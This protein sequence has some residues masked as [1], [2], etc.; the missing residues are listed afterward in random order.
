M[1]N[2]LS[3]ILII[4]L[5]IVMVFA[6]GMSASAEL[7]T[8]WVAGDH[9]YFDSA[10]IWAFRDDTDGVKLYDDLN[11]TFGTDND[12]TIEY[13]EDG[14]NKLILTCSN[15]FTLTGA[16]GITGNILMATTSQLQFHDS[17]INIYAASDSNMVINADG[18]LIITSPATKIIATTSLIHEY[19]S[20]SYVTQTVSNAGL[21]T[22]TVT[23][24][25]A[26]S[27]EIVAD[28]T[29]I[30][31]D[32]NTAV[33]LEAGAGTYG[34]SATTLD[35]N[36][37]TIT[38]CGKITANDAAGPAFIDEAVT[39]TNPTLCPNK[40]D[41]TLGVGWASNVLHL[42]VGGASELSV[43]ATAV[44][45]PTNELI[46][47][48]GNFTV[49]GSITQK[50]DA[51]DYVTTTVVATGTVKVTTTGNA[52][53]SYEI[54][55][56]DAAILL[57]AAT[58]VN[59]DAAGSMFDFT[60]TGL[61]MN[62]LTITE[63][64]DIDAADAAGPS[65]LNEAATATNP[66]L[67]PNQAEDD[68]GIGWQSDVIHIVLGTADEYSFSTSAVDFNSNN[69]GEVGTYSGT[70]A[71]TIAPTAAGT[72]LDFVLETEWVSGTL[73]NA[74][75][76]AGGVTIG[77][78]IIGMVL[79]FNANFTAVADHD[80]TG[81]KLLL[82]ALDSSTNVTTTYIGFDLNTAGAIDQSNTGTFVWK[83]INVQMPTTD[84]ATGTCTATGLHI[85]PGTITG[86]TQKGI[87][88]SGT[89]TIALDIDDATDASNLTTASVVIDGGV[90]IVKQLY[91]GDDL[92][93]S[94]SGTGVYEITLLNTNA[95]AL[96]IT[97][98]TGD[99]MVFKGTATRSVTVTPALIVTGKINT[100]DTTDASAIGTAALVS[101]GG[102]SCADELWMG[103]DIDMTTNGSGVYD[104]TLKDAVADALS[105]TRAGTDIIVFDT[106]T[107][108]VTITPVTTITGA[109]TLSG[110]L[111]VIDDQT[112]AFG[113]GSDVTMD[114]DN[115][116]GA[117]V[118]TPAGHWVAP[119]GISDRF[120]LT[121]V[122]GQRGT[123]EQNADIQD[124]AEATRMTVDPDFE[125]L[126][127]GGGA[128]STDYYA[129]GGIQL[130]TDG[131]EGHGLVMLPHLDADQT[132]WNYVTWGTDMETRW[133][134]S[135]KT[136]SV[137]T[138]CIIWAGLKLTN[139][140]TTATDNDQAFFAFDE[141]VNGGEWEAISSI[142]DS[143]DAHDTNVAVATNT[144]YHLVIEI[145]SSRLAKFYING[146]L[147]ETSAALTDTT[148]LIPYIGIEEDG[149]GGAARTL[150]IRGQAI[151]RK[152]E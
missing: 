93:M 16:L 98:G 152:F 76:A 109:L 141:D 24:D 135:I 95:D 123:P 67:I 51:D 29:T 57:D 55:T 79:D 111:I 32:A 12:A 74:D 11:L 4:P 85:T 18:T 45:L 70:G 146:T 86:G 47:T 110:G 121:W 50:F 96:S 46:I 17:A 69:L 73:I 84:E 129:E 115:T 99:F 113:T 15:G 44:T 38:E 108:K 34:F 5:L 31:L 97:D 42:V 80:I 122:A 89:Y 65:F 151:S 43:S 23:G 133:E 56:D 92:D 104:L 132:A 8:K 83:G 20:A 1:L 90:A 120:R 117:L 52:A 125:V 94:V 103:D 101:D 33:S 130:V 60:S 138:D 7:H 82:P 54:E 48:A 22:V 147:V 10:N 61:E 148:D 91:L 118:T 2:K 13:D 131:T 78:D 116:R 30:V 114:W 21:V 37:L 27:Y 112:V 119:E 126:G 106:S 100:D 139:V 39:S 77:A 72:F 144:V 107:P 149:G 9:I 25:S 14:T 137:I 19:D 3:K 58:T 66:T 75:S 136:G 49:T 142:G 41:E 128:I 102:I 124:A 62:T 68:T 26:G 36:A 87:L 143:D 63:C 134:C 59:L 145:D 150:Y 6:F 40:T 71:I 140:P 81:F 88:L 105:I 127:T 53:G 64:G 35:M 28:D